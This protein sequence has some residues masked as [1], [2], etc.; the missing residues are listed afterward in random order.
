MKNSFVERLKTQ[1]ENQ[2]QDEKYFSYEPQPTGR[3]IMLELRTRDGKRK[4]LP[5]SYMTKADFDPDIGIE[6]HVSDVIVL[7]KG[8][9]LESIYTYLLQNRLN[10]V[11]EDFSGTDIEEEDVF[12]ESIEVKTKVELMDAA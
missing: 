12:V 7:L 3:A 11:R 4:G 5:Y 6:I 9:G 1:A 2:Q 8:R 10:W